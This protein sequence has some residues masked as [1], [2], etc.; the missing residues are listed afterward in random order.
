MQNGQRGPADDSDFC[1]IRTAR[2]E[3]LKTPASH[4]APEKDCWGV[5][6]PLITGPVSVTRAVHKSI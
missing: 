6:S 5:L 1:V 2:H 3:K 4:P